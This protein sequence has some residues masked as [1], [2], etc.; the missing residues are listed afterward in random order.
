MGKRVEL[1][2]VIFAVIF[3]L[4]VMVN[5][6]P[7]SDTD[8]WWHLKAGEYIW[9]TK[10]V[11]HA[12]VFSYTMSDKPWTAH[13]W[14]AEVIYY[15]AYS[16]GNFWGLFVLNLL[17]LALTYYFYYQ[18]LQLRTGKNS[19]LSALLML[20]GAF[21][22]YFFWGFR[23][24]MFLH[25]LFVIFLYVM[26]CFYRNRDYLWIL[27]LLMI[28][29]V[30]LHGSFI[31][32]PVII[33]LYLISGIFA[34]QLPTL[35]NR[36]WTPAQKRKLLAVL[37]MS[38]LATLINPNS[39]HM[40]VYPLQTVNS[41]FIVNQINEWASP[42]FH[43]PYFM[44]YLGYV[45]AGFALMGLGKRKHRAVDLL[46]VGTFF[47]MSLYAV[48]HIA[49]FVYGAGPVFGYYLAALL[50]KNSLYKH[51]HIFNGVLT[52]KHFINGALTVGALTTA[53]L[54]W[55]PEVPLEKHVEAQVLP[56]GAVNYM[57]QHRLYGKVLNDYNWG[58]Y[59]LWTLYPDVRVMIDGRTDLYAAKVF[60]D[61]L[62]IANL[63]PQT[64]Q[65]LQ[66]Y[67]PDAIIIREG[68]S[69]DAYLSN[70]RHWQ[71]VY[72]DETAV[73]Y[74]PVVKGRHGT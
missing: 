21:F 31:M 67:Y 29:W 39:Y 16:L 66:K 71:K 27:P 51:E 17:L 61:Y 62:K 37:L 55:P 7:V 45:L 24:H 58:G 5:G 60:P 38:F 12:D 64:P 46:L 41:D 35:V 53:F 54:V 2:H 6:Q 1:Q 18:L 9:Q 69:L 33:G 57:K 59:I 32:G 22:T 50:P 23:P 63:L 74:T 13:E 47:L 20:A 25:L 15:L 3:L 40:L 8:F 65:L 56:V 36:L 72:A 34:I 70:Y 73:I 19:I 11:P 42:D 68:T 4:F 30:N 14:L 28:A 43:E 10:T 26:E 52:V 48:R 44:V 49:L